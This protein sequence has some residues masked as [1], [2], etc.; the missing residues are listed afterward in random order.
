VTP[1]AKR[2]AACAVSEW[3]DPREAA[4]MITAVRPIQKRELQRIFAAAEAA[5]RTRE[6]ATPGEAFEQILAQTGWECDTLPYPRPRPPPIPPEYE[7]TTLVMIPRALEEDAA[8]LPRLTV[9]PR[10][11]PRRRSSSRIVV[12]ALM[13]T[14]ILGALTFET[15][16]ARRLA[17]A[18]VSYVHR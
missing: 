10:S 2:G 4:L 12:A 6:P 11:A 17:R 18:V 7:G 14:V 8:T 1:P 3:N 13:A 16:Q 15:A 5:E 9:R